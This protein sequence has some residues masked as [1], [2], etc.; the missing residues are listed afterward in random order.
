MPSRPT[1]FP[2]FLKLA[3]RNVLVV[4]AGSVG[5][6]KIRAL[7][8][9]GARIRVVSLAATEAVQAWSQSGDLMLHE[10]AFVPSDLSDT[11]LVIVATSSRDLN[12]VVFDE[13]HSRD[14]LCNVVDVP[15]QCDF[16]YPAVVQ[17]GD[18]QIAISTAGQSP[19]LAQRIRQ[20]L[21]RQFSLEY[22]QWVEQ[23]GE[24]RR[25]VLAS[26]LPVQRKKDLLQSL[27]S[28]DALESEVNAKSQKHPVV[29]QAAAGTSR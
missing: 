10:R 15:E 11:F 19:S 24:T 1:L 27:A 22:A 25:Q 8:P 23:L 9:T 26:D 2:M 20:Q 17:R 4:G 6:A 14:V 3:G 29:D 5:E 21:E 13:A 7:L 28:Q 12:R 18:L 16:F